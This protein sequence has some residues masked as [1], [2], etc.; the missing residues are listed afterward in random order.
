MAD[1]ITPQHKCCPACCSLPWGCKGPHR[2]RVTAPTLPPALHIVT[3]RIASHG[4]GCDFPAPGTD[5]LQLSSLEAPLPVVRGVPVWASCPSSMPVQ[6]S[7]E[8]QVRMA[9]KCCCFWKLQNFLQTAKDMLSGDVIC[10][11]ELSLARQTPGLLRSDAALS[12]I[13]R[14]LPYPTHML[15][16]P[17]YHS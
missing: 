14:I 11:P 6:Q 16:T 9:V 8:R 7:L 3:L 15:P 5:R 17:I 2:L 10:S 1:E 4:G 12:G 13:S